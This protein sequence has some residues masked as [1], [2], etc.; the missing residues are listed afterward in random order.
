GIEI[1]VNGRFNNNLSLM[2]NYAFTDAKVTKDNNPNK[3]GSMLFGTAKHI[4]NASLKY[5]LDNNKLKGI[6]FTL[7]Y[8]FHGK[9]AAWPVTLEHPYL[10]DD[11]FILNGGIS[12]EKSN[13]QI[14]FQIRNITDRYN[15]VGFYPGAW[16]YTHYGWRALEPFN[17]RLSVSYSF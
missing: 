7:G 3:I 2:F 12:Y 4:S 8:E 9:R 1:D 11:Y 16:G 5:V 14:V 15:Y 17:Y 13:Y 10:P 6:G